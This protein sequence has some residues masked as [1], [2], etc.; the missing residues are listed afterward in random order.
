MSIAI[1]A[2]FLSIAALLAE[3]QPRRRARVLASALV[4]WF[5]A[6]VLYDVAALGVASLLRSGTAS[7]LLMTAALVNPVDAARLASLMTVE[8][9]A[10]FGA[11]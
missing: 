9:T 7:R 5:G 2:V 3:A 4:V 8:G 10:A 1:T 11:A 6:V